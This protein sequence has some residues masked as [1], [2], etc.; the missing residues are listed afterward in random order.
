MSYL[1]P[2]VYIEETLNPI[3]PLA[4]PDSTSVAAFIGAA[5]RGPLDPTLVTSWTQYTS[6]YGSWGTLN[7]LT[8]AVYLFFANGGN[9]AY[10]KRVTA[11]AAAAATRV[12]DDR[13]AT[14]DPTLNV[15]AK[16]PGTWGNSVYITITDSALAN[17]FD[18]VVY[19]G[20]TTSAFIVERY[21]DL[22]MTVGNARYAPAAINAVSNV[23]TTTD[24]NSAAT[25]VTRNPGVIALQ[26]LAAGATGSAVTESDIA[27]AMSSFDTVTSSLVLNAPGVI[28]T[29]PVNTILS[30]AEGRDDVFV[31]IDAMN[32]TVTNQMTRAATYTSTSLGAVYYPNLTIPS[33]TSSSPDAVET[34][35]C[36][37]AIVGQ[38]ISTDVSRG[39]FKAP[40]GVNNRIAGAVAVQKLTNANLDT[41]NSASAPVN[42]IRFIPGSGIVVMGSRTL[43]AGYA[44]RYVP[45]RRSLIYLRKALTDLT[46]F[47]VFE[48]NDAVLWRRIKASLEGFLTDY[49]SQGGL[50]GATPADAFFVKCDSSTNTLIKI[51]N[52]EVNMEIGVAL[53]RPAEFVII[54]IGQYDGGTTVTVA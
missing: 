9:Q 22:N 49:W 53:Q 28:S 12:F 19:N 7:T 8:T 10:V 48:P 38:F 21:T 39:V 30:Y 14:T 24:A 52:G 36:G 32:D 17:H 37:G 27:N 15:F 47:A 33:N 3:P 20:G 29:S 18:L 45:V 35:F 54:K 26:P 46:D 42:A 43:K 44:D 34:A 41:M 51:D 4:G 11:G 25:G 1:R 50:R 2:G 6:L 31:V 23:I 40:A 5:D 16:N 13:S